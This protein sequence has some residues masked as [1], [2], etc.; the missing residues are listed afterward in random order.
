MTI[1]RCFATVLLLYL[2]SFLGWAETGVLV[3]HVEDVHRHPIAGLQIGVEGDGGSAITKDDGRARIA[4]AKN[5]K[6]NTSVTLQIL[7]SPPG[8]NYDMI[9]P[10]D[11]RA[12]VPSFE[13]ES[14]NF[15]RIVVTQHG[16]RVALE[17]GSVLTALTAKINQM[18]AP[19]GLAVRAEDPKANLEAVAKQYGLSSEDL[20][21]AIQAWGTKATDPY[22]KGQAALYANNY[23]K[24][25]ADLQS[26]LNQREAK[27]ATAQKEVADAAFFLGTSLFQ[28]GK[29]R[30]SAAAYLKCLKIRPDDPLA[31]TEAAQS[32]TEAGDYS[33]AE[34]FFH[35]ARCCFHSKLHIR[36]GILRLHGGSGRVHTSLAQPAAVGRAIRFLTITI[37]MSCRGADQTGEWI[38]PSETMLQATLKEWVFRLLQALFQI[39]ILFKPE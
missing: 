19:K 39:I 33:G 9:S 18:N 16:D 31:L 4:L 13:N 38:W 7:K 15:V 20:D 36:S 21:K 32:L 17:S 8:K 6:P 24:A 26:S 1:S 22:E 14:E 12:Q 34:E 23:E 27:L 11:Y 10:W 25:T 3:V 29:Y 37:P 30:E 35:G 5:T 2:G 28:Q